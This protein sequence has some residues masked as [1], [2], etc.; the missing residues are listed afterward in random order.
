MLLHNVKSYRDH[1]LL[2]T[3]LG[4]FSMHGQ[5]GTP[6]QRSPPQKPTRV[7]Y[8]N[9]S[10]IDEVLNRTYAAKFVWHYTHTVACGLALNVC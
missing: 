1:I 9:M 8:C 5:T 4:M 3:D 2:E 10:K 7:S 6:T